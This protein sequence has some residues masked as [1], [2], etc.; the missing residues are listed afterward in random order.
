MRRCKTRYFVWEGNQLSDAV[1]L[2]EELAEK[3]KQRREILD[4]ENFQ[5]SLARK[6]QDQQMAFSKASHALS[7]Q[8]DKQRNDDQMQFSDLQHQQRKRQQQEMDAQRLTAVERENNAAYT[9]Q[10]RLGDINMAESDHNARKEIEVLNHKK[11]IEGWRLD[12]M[13]QSDKKR[14]DMVMAQAKEQKRLMNS[15]YPA[16]QLAIMDRSNSIAGS[17]HWSNMP[18]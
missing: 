12:R 1:G 17:S 6:A 4:K 5:F 3:E 18:D 2:P 7:R 10:K 14:H 11:A 16:G 8:Q 15:G 9:H 13:D